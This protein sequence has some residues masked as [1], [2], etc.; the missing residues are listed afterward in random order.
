[1]RNNLFAGITLGKETDH[2]QQMNKIKMKD[3]IKHRYTA[4][5][6]EK[7]SGFIFYSFQ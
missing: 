7:I 6:P 3:I 1:M 4:V 2:H 5:Y